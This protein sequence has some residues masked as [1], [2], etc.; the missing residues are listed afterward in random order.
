MFCQVGRGAE[1][2]S[3]PP[4]APRSGCSAAKSLDG[5]DRLCEKAFEAGAPRKEEIRELFKPGIEIDSPVNSRVG[6]AGN[7]RHNQID[8]DLFKEKSNFACLAIF[9]NSFRRTV[10]DLS[11][12]WT[13]R[14]RSLETAWPEAQ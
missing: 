4:E 14:H 12:G 1:E 13:S 9:L 11:V 2:Q 6:L 10:S 3:R 7:Q 5:S 8:P